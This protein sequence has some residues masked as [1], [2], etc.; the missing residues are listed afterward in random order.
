MA[1]QEIK[2]NFNYSYSFLYLQMG[3]K[4]NLVRRDAEKFNEYG[5]NGEKITALQD[6]HNQFRDILTDDELLGQKIDATQLKLN[7]RIDLLRVLR[8]MITRVS[9]V[10]G[11]NSG[12]YRGLGN[13]NLVTLTDLQVQEVAQRTYRFII[14]NKNELQNSGLNDE[15]IEEFGTLTEAF[16][17]SLYAT[18]DT[19]SNRDIATQS[20]RLL[21]NQVY[22]SLCSICE[23]GKTVWLNAGDLAKANDYKVKRN[24]TKKKAEATPKVAPEATPEAKFEEAPPDVIPKEEKSENDNLEAPNA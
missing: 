18:K 20:R 5:I 6:L 22:E 4:I 8:S 15:N 16:L 10:Y 19:V 17:N 12:Q 21:A 3:E 1:G 23:I 2:R 14:E 24:N 7:A 9:L 13:K 11:K